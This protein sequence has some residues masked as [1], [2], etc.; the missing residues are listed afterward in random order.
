[1]TNMGAGTLRLV[2]LTATAAALVVFLTHRAGVLN[3][4]PP[5]GVTLAAEG[6]EIIVSGPFVSG[7]ERRFRAVLD[8]A[9]NARAV[10]LH[11]IGGS[12]PVAGEIRNE[13][14][15]R[16]LDTVVGTHCASACTVAFLAGA[17]RVLEPGGRLGFHRF[18]IDGRETGA[19]DSALLRYYWVAGIAQ[20]FIDRA[21][22][23]PASQMWYPAATELR[24][25]GVVTDIPTRPGWW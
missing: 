10:R 2:L 22:A 9:P 21:V 20:D 5:P 19:A 11:S 3:R 4:A 23:T 6:R 13:I 15:A 7:L 8:H 24:A 18:T 14:R 17:R 16:R 25:A 1:M 12:L